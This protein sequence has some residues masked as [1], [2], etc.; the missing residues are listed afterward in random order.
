M[1]TKNDGMC[2]GIA[3]KKFGNLKDC[4]NGVFLGFGTGVGTAVFI[5]DELMEEVRSI[6]S[7]DYRKKWK[8]VHLRK[9]WML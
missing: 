1:Y 3:E 7:Y 2:A 9:K 4:H 5:Q 6:R 8:K